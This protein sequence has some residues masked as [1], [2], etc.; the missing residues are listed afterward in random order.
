L[1][2]EHDFLDRVIVTQAIHHEIGSTDSVCRRF[3]D[4]GAF[5]SERFGFL[6]GSI[7]NSDLIAGF[8]KIGRHPAA[9]RAEAK[10]GDVLYHA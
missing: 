7:P 10:I 2:P 8:E 5:P 4:A 6:G 1:L 3:R 9:H